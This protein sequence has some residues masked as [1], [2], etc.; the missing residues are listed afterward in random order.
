M[1]IKSYEYWMRKYWREGADLEESG[2]SDVTYPPEG[3]AIGSFT[4]NSEGSGR[5]K[6]WSEE[7]REMC[8]NINKLLMHQRG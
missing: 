8:N 3:S 5:Y 1:Y 2:T 4:Y 6:G 7:G